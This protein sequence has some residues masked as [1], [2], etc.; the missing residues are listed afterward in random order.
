MTDHDVVIVG[1]GLA[2]L[3]AAAVLARRGS[4]SACWTPPTGP[5][6]GSRPTSWTGSGSTAGS[7]CSTRSTRRCARRS[8]STRCACA[9]SCRAPRSAPA[10]ARCTR[11]ATRCAAPPSPGRPPPTGC[12][13]RSTRPGSSRG[14]RRWSPPR[15]SARRRGS[16]G[17]PPATSP[18]RTSTGRSSSSSCGRSFPACLR[19]RPGH[20]G[21][22]RAAGVALLRARHHRG[23]RRRHGRAARPP[24]RG[25][26]GEGAVDGAAGHPRRTRA[27]RGRR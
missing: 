15:R 26:A 7:R 23:A 25:P 12:S 11:S 21:G 20:V 8:T 13:G 6:A 27:G 16:T 22:V 9:R 10:T 4:T 1:A 18:P 3:R 2:G 19:P 14:P 17:A 24:R 5:A